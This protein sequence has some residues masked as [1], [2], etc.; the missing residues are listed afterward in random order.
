VAAACTECGLCGKE[1]GFLKKYGLPKEIAAGYD[2]AA[3]AGQV[4]PFECSLCRLCDALCPFEANPASLFLEMRREAVER[5]AGDFPEHKGLL[6]YEAK[7]MSRRFTWYGLPAGCETVFFPGCALPG[8]RPERTREIFH[9]LR[10]GYPQL[11]IVLD[12]CGKISHDLGREASFTAMF[13]EMMDYLTARGVKEVI[14]AC[15]N[16]YDIFSRYGGGLG[17]RTVFEAL[18]ATAAAPPFP[19]GEAVIHDPCGTRFHD[20][21]RRAVRQ[22]LAAA[23]L[24]PREMRHTAQQAF[25]CGNGAGV[26]VLSPELADRWTDRIREEAAGRPLM[27]YCSG[28]AG[29][30]A[31]HV[32]AV[33]VLDALCEPEAA[34]A[35]KSKVSRAPFTYLNRLK[36]KAYF[37]KTLVPVAARERTFTAVPPQ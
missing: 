9:L 4:M 5:N 25:C 11:G 3:T 20:G 1:C 33:H 23:G 17:V 27:T 18:P 15:P 35:G 7:G 24:S 8:T 21:A 34:L 31:G 2:P 19:G 6:A 29:R 36:L 37:Q 13:G 10:K 30:L 32:R 28:C 22:R 14:V 16:C 26:N 12:C